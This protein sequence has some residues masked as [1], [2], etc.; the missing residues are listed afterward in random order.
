M[1]IFKKVLP[2][3]L[4]ASLIII[5]K[6]LA[7]SIKDIRNSSKITTNLQKEL[8]QKRLKNEFLKQQ[9]SY[10]KTDEFVEKEAREKLGL[11]KE[12]ESVVIPSQEEDKKQPISNPSLPNW[13]KWWSLFF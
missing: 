5:I 3:L 2:F 1:E 10:V 7:V 11:V 12:G 6:N 8:E 4:I 9:L 13:K